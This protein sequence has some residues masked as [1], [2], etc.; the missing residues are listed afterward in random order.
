MIG[1]IS[2]IHGNYEALKSVLK[3]LDE[4]RINEIY[5]LGDVVGYYTQVNECCDELRQRKVKCIMGNHDWYMVMDSFCPRSKS[6]NDCL[7]YQRKVISKKNK[8]WLAAF[9]LYYNFQNIRMVHGGWT[10][11]IDEYLEPN[12]EYFEKMPEGIYFS[13]HSHIQKL[14][15]R[16]GHIYCN[17]G[18]VGQPRD[19]K[20][21]AAFAVLDGDK[22]ELHR[23][24]YDISKVAMLME[25]KGFS[26]YYYECLTVGA[27]TLGYVKK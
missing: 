12:E 21:T 6:V 25:E 15:I 14:F 2:D 26:G 1:I 7:Q 27:K 20:N 23:V 10:N 9:P 18:S 19:G 17:P 4:Q 3:Y 5:C 11:P 22:V 16:E 13:G 24:P 8:E